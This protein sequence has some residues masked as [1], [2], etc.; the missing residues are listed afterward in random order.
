MIVSRREWSNQLLVWDTAKGNGTVRHSNIRAVQSL[1]I[2]VS[3]ELL[4]TL[5]YTVLVYSEELLVDPMATFQGVL[6]T[7]TRGA[8]LL[9]TYPGCRPDPHKEP[10]SQLRNYRRTRKGHR[11]AQKLN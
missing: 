1:G 9:L 2:L 3:T 5:V 10:R 8:M 11:S 7:H 6:A 4:S